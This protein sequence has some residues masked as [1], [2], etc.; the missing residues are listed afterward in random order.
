VSAPTSR[1]TRKRKLK[2]ELRQLMLDTDRAILQEE[3]I[4]TASNDLTFKRV[5]DRVERTTRR[6]LTNASIFKRVWENQSDYQA[7]VLVDIAHDEQRPEV[8]GTLVS[9]AEVLDDV[10]LNTVDGRLRGMSEICRVVGGASRQLIAESTSWWL[11]I[12]VVTIATTSS[13]KYQKERMCTALVEGYRPVAEFWE[14]S[15]HGLMHHLGLRLRA[16]RTLLQ[17]SEVVTSLCDGDSLHQH[18][19]AGGSP[20]RPADRACRRNAGVDAL[21]R[22]PRSVGDPVLRAG[23]RLRRSVTGGGRTVERAP[24]PPAG[25]ARPNCSVGW[26]HLG[27]PGQPDAHLVRRAV[28]PGHEVGLDLTQGR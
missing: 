18:V 5:S 14:G 21:R 20:P 12:S 23:P 24:E 2:R 26:Q 1:G 13:N 16:S 6:Q 15:Y 9:V 19:V 3:G 25:T 7:D 4:E 22:H 8:E 17:F 10:D 11:W 28:A 27:R